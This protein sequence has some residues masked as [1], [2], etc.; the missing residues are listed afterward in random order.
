MCAPS[1]FVVLVPD[2]DLASRLGSEFF[3]VGTC[4]SNQPADVFGPNGDG[5]RVLDWGAW[6]SD[7]T[8]GWSA[9][10]GPRASAAATAAT[11]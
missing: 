10:T 11:R 9:P 5:A 4:G 1:I 2:F 3:D 7:W 8:A 6:P